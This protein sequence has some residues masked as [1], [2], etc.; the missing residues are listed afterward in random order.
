MKIEYYDVHCHF[1]DV[2]FHNKIKNFI[3]QSKSENIKLWISSALDPP[4]IEFHKA[5]TQKYQN[6]KYSIGIHPYDV[7]RYEKF[8]DSAIANLN[9]KNCIAIGE[10]GLDFTDGQKYRKEQS[11]L[12][13][14]LAQEAYKNNLPMILHLRKSYYEFL[15]L[16]K[17]KPFLKEITYIIHSFSG[18][19]A[20][21]DEFLKFNIYF[22][23]NGAIIAPR[24]NKLREK[25]LKV[26]ISK[27]LLETDAPYIPLFGK[28]Q[29]YNIPTNIKYV[30]KA[31]ANI[32]NISEL[33]LC[34]IIKNNLK[35]IFHNKI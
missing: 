16:L 34:Q 13:L 31:A 14:I 20:I 21:I 19:L 18:P 35:K 7:L 11:N 12:F 2:R 26:P 10:T 5:L 29:N 22:S 28:N 23:F 15:Q 32:L 8:L 1:D 27:L 6:I 33:E 30:Y 25:L 4:S 17:R 9:N 3:T 24:A